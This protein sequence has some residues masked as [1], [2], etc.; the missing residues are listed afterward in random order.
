LGVGH[1]AAP[2]FVALGEIR[3]EGVV[4]EEIGYL[5]LEVSGTEI[6]LTITEGTA[7]LALE[8]F[9]SALVSQRPPYFCDARLEP[10]EIEVA[11]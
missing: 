2:G 4:E 9:A 10:F 6:S 5:L 11:S 7:T 8:L 1:G 3:G